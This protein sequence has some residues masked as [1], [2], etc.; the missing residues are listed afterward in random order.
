MDSKCQYEQN[1]QHYKFN[2]SLMEM[3]IYNVLPNDRFYNDINDKKNS[4]T[5]ANQAAKCEA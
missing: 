1:R 2:F 3:V 5:V 4:M